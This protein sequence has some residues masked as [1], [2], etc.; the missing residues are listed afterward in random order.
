MYENHSKLFIVPIFYEK[1]S[2]YPVAIYSLLF[3][4]F[5]EKSSWKQSVW[6]TSLFL[7]VPWVEGPG[8]SSTFAVPPSCMAIYPNRFFEVCVRF[9][10]FC[11]PQLNVGTLYYIS[12]SF[13]W[14]WLKPL[15]VYFRNFWL[16]HRWR[17]PF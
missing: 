6:K 15:S 2:K 3:Y 13:S 11:L 5:V 12:L 17:T 10:A 4:F 16:H 1:N 8:Y 7:Q 14:V 9:Y